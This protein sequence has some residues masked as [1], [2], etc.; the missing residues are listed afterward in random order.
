MLSSSATNQQPPS[1]ST[2]STVD[3]YTV[4]QLP[5]DGT[6][7]GQNNTFVDSSTNNYAF[8]RVGNVTQGSFT[9]FSAELGKWS[10][11]FNGASDYYITSTSTALGFGTGDFTIE[12]W[13]YPH[14]ISSGRGLLD[15]RSVGSS[16]STKPSLYLSANG[17][18]SYYTNGGSRITGTLAANQW[19][20]IA[21]CRASGSTAMYISG[22]KVG[23]SYVS[24]SDM[25]TTSDVVIGQVGYTRPVAGAYWNGMITNVRVIKTALYTTN[26]TPSAYPLISS[27]N[28]VP[29]SLLMLYGNILADYSTNAISTSQFGT[30]SIV[31]ISV[32][33]GSTYSAATMGGS[34]LVTT[35][36]EY[37]S[38]A[39]ASAILTT[40]QFSI[41]GW[42]YPTTVVSRVQVMGTRTWATGNVAG[43]SVELSS[44]GAVSLLASSGI[45][46]DWGV[47]VTSS[48]QIKARNWSHIAIT[49]DASNT[50]RLFVN[51]ALVGSITDSRSLNLSNG[52]TATGF[53]ISGALL[54]GIQ[55][56][57]YL[58][59]VSGIRVTSSAVYT[60]AFA[61]PI[62]PPTAIAT[63]RALLNFTNASVYDSSGSNDVIT[64]GNTR[65]STTQSKIGGSS[66]FF[67]G[68]D[69]YLLTTS[70][71]YVLPGDFT[72][73]CWVRFNTINSVGTGLFQLAAVPFAAVSGLSILVGSSGGA[74]FG[75]YAGSSQYYSTITPVINQWYHV[76]LVRSGTTTKLYIDG[77]STTVSVTDTVAYT[78]TALVVGGTYATNEL[79]T[80]YIDN[81]RL[82]VG[83]ARYTTNFTPSV[84]GF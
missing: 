58:G 38:A 57:S 56:D 12:C 68:T 9:P 5:G 43:W 69:D 16:T 51:G 62:A 52:M 61:P 37:I 67:D 42:V 59:Y 44:A 36:G 72:I 33:G 19:S 73:E 11:L 31:P 82:S 4:L 71:T 3:S 28:S 34:I 53:R 14:S 41:E 70:T 66:I 17:V 81:F 76:A 23:G 45:N 7:G 22:V 32:F 48:N 30:P 26:F 25:G 78:G 55:Q 60:T 77:S 83:I 15:F 27:Q 84:T 2:Q 21:I 75:I 1:A 8:T 63:T 29:A 64:Y 74:Q 18:L 35:A 13:V 65:I 47:L 46:N 79:L 10:A 80:G 20:H 54:D 50:I 6:N 40:G 39:A 24:S 49:R